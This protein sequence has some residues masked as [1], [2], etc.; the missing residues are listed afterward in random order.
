[1]KPG[2]KTTEFWGGLV[3]PQIVGLLAT[4]GIITSEQ[5]QVLTDVGMQAPEVANSIITQVMGLVTMVGSAFGY[6]MSRGKAKVSKE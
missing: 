4:F 2:Y 5:T 1:M 3:L 6:S